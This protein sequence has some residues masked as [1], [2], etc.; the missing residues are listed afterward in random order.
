M[1]LC[2]SYKLGVVEREVPEKGLKFIPKPTSFNKLELRKD[3]HE[4]HRRL[5]ILDHFS[6]NLDYSHL[7]FINPSMREPETSTTSLSTKDLITRNV[8]AFRALKIPR[9]NQ[10]HFKSNITT[11][12][13]RSLKSLIQL[14]HVIIKP[15]DKGSQIVLQDRTSYLI[16][17]NTLTANAA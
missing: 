1:N 5:K 12:L 16:E 10:N 17:A 7:P 3:L 15:A 11:Q 4:Y 13:R 9:K 8:A 2:A 14:D 6:Y